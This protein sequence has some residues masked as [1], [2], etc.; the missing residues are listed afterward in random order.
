MMRAGDVVII[1]IVVAFGTEAV[2]G[3]AIGETLTQFNYMPVFGVATATVMLVARSLGE[4]DFEQIDRVADVIRQL[5]ET[6]AE[7]A[8]VIG[9]GNIWRGRQGPAAKMTAVNADHMG[10]LGTAINSIAMQDAVERQ[11]IA[12]RVMSAVEMTRFC[13]PYTYRRAVRHLEKG[14][15]VIFA[16]GTGNPFFSTDTAAALRAV[17]IG[18]DAILLAKNV[19]GV[20]D[21]DPRVNP[22]AKL[23]RDITYQEVQERDLKVMDAS[24]ITICRENKV[25]CIR[26]FGLDD[27]Q[28]ILRV[29]EGDMMGT[30]VHP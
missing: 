23:L 7:I 5:H 27:P 20:Y 24:A 29:I 2:A 16:C 30:V 11:G 3:N 12:S 21:S 6:G 1:A 22:E 10:M 14:R 25:P 8:I 15:V 26:V 17:E 19:D 9:A 13:E 4:G 28:N 18:A